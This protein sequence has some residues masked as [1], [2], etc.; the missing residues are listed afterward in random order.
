MTLRKVERGSEPLRGL[1]ALA[2]PSNS[3]KTFSALRVATGIRD[4][5][6]AGGIAMIDTE[7]RG[8]LYEGRFEF[9]RF[10]LDP[11]F[12]PQ[13]WLDAFRQL[14]QKYS[15]IISDNFSDEHEGQGGLIDMAENSGT[16]QDAAKWAR[17]KAEHKA[18]MGKVRLLRSQHL[19]LL[20]AA[21]KIKIVD[22][23][24]KRGE[25]CKVVEPQGWQP[26]CE[27]NFIYDITLG[28]MLPPGSQGRGDIWKTIDGFDF[29]DGE[30]LSEDHGRR[31]A[32]W[33]RG[34][35]A[36]Q[37]APS[38]PLGTILTIRRDMDIIYQGEDHRA[39][40]AAYG[41]HAKDLAGDE[42]KL[43]EFRVA[44]FAAL[45]AMLARASGERAE[46]LRAEIAG[47]AP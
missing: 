38:A 32:A 44:N 9:D 6:Q 11:P 4:G 12:S 24:N 41:P 29:A 1:I 18:L 5:L 22:G 15:V 10:V 21:D 39:A 45:Q 36:P 31:I 40:L 17:P 25:P 37:A 7:L 34:E 3:G 33:I 27:K 14:D 47:V 28:W 30:Q 43:A 2:G 42:V 35:T 20:R 13:A 23:V 26:V 19:F 46:F 8:N 16:K